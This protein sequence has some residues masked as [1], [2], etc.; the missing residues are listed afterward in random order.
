MRQ[1]YDQARLQRMRA[2]VLLVK[3]KLEAVGLGVAS[4]ESEFLGNLVL[5][6]GRTVGEAIS[7]HLAEALDGKNLPPL[8]PERTG[9]P[10]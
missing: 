7:E 8:L 4:I 9:Q 1:A 2:L 5:P 10:A 3:A 6:G